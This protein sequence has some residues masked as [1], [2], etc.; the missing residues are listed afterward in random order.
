MGGSLEPG[1]VG[2]R[3]QTGLMAFLMAFGT[4]G[5]S[6]LCI[7]GMLGSIWRSTSSVRGLSSC[8]SS[9]T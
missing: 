4:Q 3:N 9:G 2:N 1:L 6:F 7:L 8:I 5:W